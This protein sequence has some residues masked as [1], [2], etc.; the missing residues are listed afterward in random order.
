MGELR[1]CK[2]HSESAKKKKK[3]KEREKE[4]RKALELSFNLP[5]PLTTGTLLNLI[6]LSFHFSNRGNAT[7]AGSFFLTHIKL[8]C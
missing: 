8:N 1:F 4:R 7:E 3:K 2:P 6:T 5:L